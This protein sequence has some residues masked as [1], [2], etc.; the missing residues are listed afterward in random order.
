MRKHE[1][2]LVADDRARHALP[3]SV[4]DI[5]V[6]MID[7]RD[8]KALASVGDSPVLVDVDLRD[9]AKVSSIRDHLSRSARSPC[10]IIAVDRGSHLSEAQANGLGASDLIR[11]PLDVQ[12]LRSVLHRHFPPEASSSEEVPPGPHQEGFDKEP[13]G[14][15]I[16]TAAAELHRMFTALTP[17]R[18]LDMTKVSQAG[19]QIVEAIADVGLTKWL[20]TVRRYHEGTFQHCLI[21]TGVSTAFGHGTGMRRSD[22]LTITI[23]GLLHDI[24]KAE[25]PL[26]ILD[27]PGKLTHE[28]FDI[29]KRHPG[30]GYDYLRTQSAVVSPEIY[31]VVRHHHEYLDGSGYPDGLQAQQINDL[32]R[33]LTICDVYGALVEQR[34]YRSPKSPELALDILTGMAA[35][36]KVEYELVRALDSCVKG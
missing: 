29:I 5:T 25:I 34:P 21:V 15:S 7:W 30:I 24:G 4:A 26:E 17:G 33:I 12:S 3:G 20:N 14:S 18:P 16:I 28:E 35:D 36:G 6:R 32:T 27:K 1:L 23:A 31:D 9:A 13:G 10:R 8:K 2:V 19:D 22:V 11:R